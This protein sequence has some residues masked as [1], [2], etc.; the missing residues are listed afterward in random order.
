M[1][2]K[3]FRV[4]EGLLSPTAALDQQEFTGWGHCRPFSRPRAGNSSPRTH[5]RD[6]LAKEVTTPPFHQQLSRSGGDGES[7]TG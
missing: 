3:Y 7:Y 5:R 6:W 4:E 2:S 1:V